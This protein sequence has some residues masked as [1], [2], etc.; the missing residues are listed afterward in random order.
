MIVSG[1][2]RLVRG[3][4]IPFEERTRHQMRVRDKFLASIDDF[5]IIGN[6]IKGDDTKVARLSHFGKLING[7]KFLPTFW[8]FTGSC[9][10]QGW[11]QAVRHLSIIEILKLGQPELALMP[12]FGYIYGRSRTRGGLNGRGEGSFGSAAA[13]A[14]LKDGVIHC[15]ENGVPTPAFSIDGNNSLIW[16]RDRATASSNEMVWSDGARISQNL[17]TQGRKNLVKSAAQVTT[18]KQVVE[19][20]LNGYPVP[21][22]SNAGFERMERKNGKLWGRRSGTWMHQMLWIDVDLTGP[23]PAVLTWNSWST[24]AHPRPEDDSPPGSFWITLDDVEFMARQG[25]TFAISQFDGFPA[26]KLRV[27]DFLI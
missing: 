9:V 26:Q 22:A 21:V 8:Q 19:A 20:L 24:T 18:A 6:P 25:D 7:G 15:G 4:W 11:S 1:S 5:N 13:E 2:D 27:E 12:W 23:D 10:G 16:G 3:G 14:V 17:I